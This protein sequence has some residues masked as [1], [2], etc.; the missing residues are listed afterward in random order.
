MKYRVANAELN[1][2]N[3]QEE[4]EL[5]KKQLE[6]VTSAKKILEE[7]VATNKE[8]ELYSKMEAVDEEYNISETINEFLK[9]S[10]GI[11]SL[12]TFIFVL[13]E[14]IRNLQEENIQSK[15]P[16]K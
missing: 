13:Q 1:C 8:I 14:K 15:N 3:L 12:K 11:T 9:K 7:K 2:S 6:E 5:L 10:D 4:N 16:Y